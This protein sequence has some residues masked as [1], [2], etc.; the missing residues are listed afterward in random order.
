MDVSVIIATKNEAKNIGKC[1]R[2]IERQ[3]YRQNKIEVIVVD[4]NSED[5]TNEIA[6]R[7]TPNVHNWGPERSAQRNFGVKEAKGK[8]ILCLDADMILSENVISE[9]VRKCEGENMIALHIP[10]RVIGNGFFVKVRNFEISFYKATI[11]EPVRFIRRDRFLEVEGFDENLT[12]GEDWDFDRRVRENVDAGIINSPLY[13]NVGKF[14]ITEYLTK[15]RYYV[16]GL[17]EYIG[18]WGKDDPIIK[19]QFGPWYR[20]FEV[21]T[22]NGKW[23]RLL[24]HPMLTLGMYL[25]KFMV[26]AQYLATR[27]KKYRFNAYHTIRG[28]IA[29]NADLNA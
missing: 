20:F 17:N 9:C 12:G 15:K 5:K 2:S 11:I 26:G 24:E 28:Y 18:K 22:E 27:S 25:L 13:L 4:N 3:S 21:F 19:K 14:D 7:N 10:M 1:I 23:K 8:Y 6:H 29:D 16:K